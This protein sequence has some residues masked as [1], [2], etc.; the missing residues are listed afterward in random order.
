MNRIL[1]KLERKLGGRAVPHLTGVM[2][3]CF[4]IGY[5]LEM[6]YPNAASY[7]NLDIYQVMHGQVWRLITWIVI[8][9]SEINIFTIIMLFFYLSIGT[10]LERIWGTF[11]YN[12][13]IFGGMLITV[14]SAFVTYFIFCHIY[15]AGVTAN[16]FTA[17]TGGWPSYVGS[18]TGA[19]FNT[20]N[21][22]TSLLLA[23]AATFPTATVLLMF[24]IP[25]QMKYMGLI[26]GAFVIYDCIQYVRTFISSGDPRYL[27][28]C[29]AIAAVML[30][31][32]V[33]FA[34]NRTRFRPNAEQRRRQKEFKKAYERGRA[35]A[36]KTYF[37]GKN[38]ADSQG[39]KVTDLYGTRHRCEVCGR[40][41]IS[42][43]D[44][45][46]RYCSKCAGDHEY[47]M[48]HLYTHVHIDIRAQSTTNTE[49]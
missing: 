3:G 8:P 36:G 21:I 18:A 39:A 28:Y 43:P 13:Y 7:M 19:F 29:I 2:I 48:E 37:T 14:L 20:Y 24:V 23:F 47:C 27:I 40:T 32:A 30:N 35:G 12:V 6:F 17:I 45:E 5:L 44:L 31:F 4:V 25:I 1:E 42:D 46:F 49:V 10:S 11:R 38:A 9:P 22:C 15:P 41:E 33:F 34:M 16:L 26:Y